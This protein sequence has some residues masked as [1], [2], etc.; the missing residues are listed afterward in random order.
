MTFYY[1]ES[2]L[3]ALELGMK[4]KKQAV[5]FPLSVAADVRYS[6]VRGVLLAKPKEQRERV[7]AR[8]ILATRSSCLTTAATALRTATI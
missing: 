3:P 1:N 7:G 6:P 5:V 4:V 2:P 8:Y